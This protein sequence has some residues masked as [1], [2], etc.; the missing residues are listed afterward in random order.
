MTIRQESKL[1]MYLALRVFLKENTVI[2]ETLP[3]WK[4]FMALLD[5]AIAQ[6]QKYGEQQ[7]SDTTGGTV[8]K[9]QQRETLEVTCFLNSTRI[10]AY[11]LYAKDAALALETKYVV[12]DL[13][14]LTDMELVN[15]CRKLYDMINKNLWNLMTYQLSD[16]TQKAF[17]GYI[18]SF[19][20]A[21]PKT[22]NVL[23]ERK[24]STRLLAEGFEKA[25]GVIVNMD[26]LVEIVRYTQANFYASYKDTERVQDVHG[27]LQAQG[28]VTDSVTGT[29]IVDATVTFTLNG[30]TKPTLV[31]ETALKGG[32]MVKNL[33]EGIYLVMVEK[34][35]YITQTLSVT[36]TPDALCNIDVLLVKG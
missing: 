21:I 9:R 3:N 16:A 8:T 32:F 26:A 17:L 36:V 1:K 35:G 18:N 20:E 30:E 4:D 29:P 24:E 23:V 19:E 6:I 14:K 11:A 28:V 10:H 22:K 34:T 13:K 25:D 7:L 31:K 27:T 5:T 15:S 33:S 2:T 12:S